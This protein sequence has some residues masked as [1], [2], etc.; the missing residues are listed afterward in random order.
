MVFMS[1]K[2]LSL[3]FPSSLPTKLWTE[4][5]LLSQGLAK[6]CSCKKTDATAL[7]GFIHRPSR[8]HLQLHVVLAAIMLT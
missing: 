1:L 5:P 4:T 8:R 3:S 2:R 6:E 7:V